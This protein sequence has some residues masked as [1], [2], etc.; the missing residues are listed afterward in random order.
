M[1]FGTRGADYRGIGGG[2]GGVGE[3]RY[4]AVFPGSVSTVQRPSTRRHTH[5]QRQTAARSVASRVATFFYGEILLHSS[6]FSRDRERESTRAHERARIYAMLGM[7]GVG[8]FIRKKKRRKNALRP[9]QPHQPVE[10]KDSEEAS[11]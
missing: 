11:S 9:R 6:L 4:A 1:P 10:A 8:I 3:E 7:V 5:R 2:V